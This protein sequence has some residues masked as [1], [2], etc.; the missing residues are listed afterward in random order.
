[1]RIKYNKSIGSRIKKGSFK[2]GTDYKRRVNVF[3]SLTMI[4]NTDNSW[5]CEETN[6]WGNI[7][8]ANHNSFSSDNH[9][10]KNLKQ[11]IRHIKNHKELKK[12]TIMRLCSNFVGY[13]IDII[14]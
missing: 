2:I 11:A 12:G 4:S 8:D 14:I 7:E 5:W 9:D 6:R 13:S 1:M 10:I 3:S